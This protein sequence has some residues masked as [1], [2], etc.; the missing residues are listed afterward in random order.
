[1]KSTEKIAA[2]P[3]SSNAAA[4][5][6]S[7]TILPANNLELV[8]AWGRASQGISHV[9]R[10]TTVD[11][12]KDLFQLA[13][14]AGSHIG[15]RGGG[16]SYGDAAMND[17]NILVD[18]RRMNRILGWDPKSGL[19]TLEPGVTLAQLWQYTLEDGWWPPVV[20]GTMA[21]TIGGC[22][23]M[24]V[25]G[26]NAWQV[27]PIGDHITSFDLLLAS[28]E[29][30][31]C[32]RKRNSDLFHAAIGGFGVLGCFTA[33]TM[34]M[35]PVY[36][37]LLEVQTE[38]RANLAEMFSYFEENL[39]SSDYIV[40]WIDA[41]ASGDSLG[42]GDVHMANYLPQGADPYP[43]QTMQLSNQHLPDTLLG[44]VPKSVIWMFM[45]PFMNNLG[46]RIIN[47]AKYSAGRLG[48]PKA[49]RQPHAAFHFLL[50]YVPNWKQAYGSRGLI[51]YQPFIPKANAQDTFT[52]IL[53]LC[54]QRGLPNYLTVMKRHRPD[55]F[56][57]THGLDGYSMAMDF[58]IT[59]RNRGR[60]VSLIRE[61]DQIVLAAEGRFYFAKDSTLDRETT[62]SYLGQG[63]IEKFK[64]LKKRYDPDCLLQSNLWRRLFS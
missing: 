21:T 16:N 29:L 60:I 52:E 36:S 63:T 51:Q 50:D 54:Q 6:P 38:S 56:L 27:G 58:R 41:F 28:G 64:A 31:S 9:Y 15:F 44:L 10:P 1:M 5:Q 53:K 18:L 45:L 48:G 42:R 13:R 59:K 11:G 55:N 17:E 34:Q 19:I 3:A 39:E 30:V 62:E 37:G 24:N 49:S 8:E 26:K 40:G 43:S 35:K 14:A 61:L 25:H 33:V 32:D 57:L 2:S 46:T 12:L 47:S 4:G 22:A 23:G 7:P 20:T